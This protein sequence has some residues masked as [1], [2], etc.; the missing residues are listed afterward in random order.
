MPIQWIEALSLRQKMM[1][2]NLF[3]ITVTL[4]V[5][6]ALFSLIYICYRPTTLDRQRRGHGSPVGPKYCGDAGVRG[7]GLPGDYNTRVLIPID[8]ERINE[9]V[10]DSALVGSEFPVDVDLIERV[11]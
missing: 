8:G 9:T 7:F 11:E 3:G 6:F 10:Y 1:A 4:L 5:T 2:L